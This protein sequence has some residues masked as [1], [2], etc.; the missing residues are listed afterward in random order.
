MPADLTRLSKF[1][2]LVLRHA[3][4]RFGLALDSEGFAPVA[5]VWALVQQRFPDRYSESDLLAVT[6]VSADGK[7]RFEIAGSRIRARYGH[8]AAQVSYP[9]AVPPER[10]YHGT[11]AE[12][13][14]GI[15]RDGLL[16]GERQF[17]HLSLDADWAAQ[18]GRRHSA[19]PV[20]LTV[21]A[22]DMH[23]AGWRFYN[24]EPRHYLTARVP[25]A[26][27]LFAE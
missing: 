10:L 13:L 23:R 24:P 15:R 16:P 2:S 22:G 21:Y 20:V 19:A 18:V 17:V 11:A 6:G 14:A 4:E 9:P 5:E 27:I 8:S 12:A 7:Q 3:P 26:F 1:L 25:P